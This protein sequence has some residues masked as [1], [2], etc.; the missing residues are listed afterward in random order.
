MDSKQSERTN[1]N[2]VKPW[3][4]AMAIL[5]GT[6]WISTLPMSLIWSSQS[7]FLDETV[8]ILLKGH[9]LLRKLN[10][11]CYHITLLISFVNLLLIGLCNSKI[12]PSSMTTNLQPSP[13]KYVS[14]TSDYSLL[15]HLHLLCH[16]HYSPGLFYLYS[17][18]FSICISHVFHPSFTL[19]PVNSAKIIDLQKKN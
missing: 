11:P 18:D 6:S 15:F 1:K 13:A 5:W 10:K 14:E 19:P 7:M 8:Y 4:T 9:L 12:F 2:A 17:T 16:H 3:I